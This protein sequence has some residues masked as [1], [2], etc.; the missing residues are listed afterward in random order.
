MS[1]AR[2]ALSTTITSFIFHMHHHALLDQPLP[3]GNGGGWNCACPVTPGGPPG[4]GLY[5]GGSALPPAPG[6]GEPSIQTGFVTCPGGRTGTTGREPG[7]AA[8]SMDCILSGDVD[9]DD[10][11]ECV[12]CDLNSTP[13]CRSSGLGGLYTFVVVSFAFDGLGVPAACSCSACSS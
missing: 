1:C 8:P 4:L 7:G 9:I 13:T 6:G 5:I 11:E 3:S 10:S 12:Q 2:K